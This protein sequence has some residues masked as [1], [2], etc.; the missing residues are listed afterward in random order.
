M[1]RLGSPT[2]VAQGA[3]RVTLR[4]VRGALQDPG[5]VPRP[6]RRPLRGLSHRQA[7]AARAR[8]Q[9]HGAGQGVLRA[10]HQAVRPEMIS[11]CYPFVFARLTN[12]Y[13]VIIFW[14]MNDS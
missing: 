14:R 10:P 3:G 4:H 8:G 5:E 9:G 2:A 11:I 12:R 7:A 13:S 1:N 6:D